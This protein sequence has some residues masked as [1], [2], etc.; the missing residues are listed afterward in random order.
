MNASGNGGADTLTGGAGDDVFDGGDGADYVWDIVPNAAAFPNASI[1][2]WSFYGPGSLTIAP[3][4]SAD[5]AGSPGH[6]LDLQ[7]VN[8][9]RLS[10][11][12]FGF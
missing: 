3:N 5:I 10:Y 11:S 4:T 12:G 2:G 8:Q 7:L 6:L 1:E 9:G